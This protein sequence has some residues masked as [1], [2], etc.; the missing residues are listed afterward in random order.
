M[1]NTNY[2][3]HDIYAPKSTTKLTDPRTPFDIS[4][5]EESKDQEIDLFFSIEHS[6]VVTMS[7]IEICKKILKQL[8][9]T[10]DKVPFDIR[11][12]L[13]IVL[14]SIDGAFDEETNLVNEKTVYLMADLLA[15]CWLSG[16]F[17][18][19]ECFGMSMTLK[20]EY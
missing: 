18:W 20:D 13:R 7:C 8:Y 3:L 9:K 12:M 17:R 16:G 4:A 6:Q 5:F 11:V 10:V 2:L 15:G 14:S 19:Q 1:F